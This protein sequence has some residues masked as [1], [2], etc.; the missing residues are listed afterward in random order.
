[1]SSQVRAGAAAN[2]DRLVNVGALREAYYGRQPEPSDPAQ[3]V[4][5]G[6]N[7]HCGS[8]RQGTFNEG[9]V[10]AITQAICNYRRA[11]SIT[12][13]L[14]LGRDTHA[15]SE[16]A[17]MTA[18]EVLVANRVECVIDAAD[19]PTP[20]PAVSHAVVTCNRHRASG[21]ADGIVIT[22]SHDPPED[23]GLKYSP[24]HGGPAGPDDSRWIEDQANAL[25]A[26]SLTSVARIPYRR[27]RSVAT[28]RRYDYV[29]SYV[30]E[31]STVLDLDLIRLSKLRIGV[32]PMGGSS[33]AIWRLIFERCELDVE[34]INA[35]VDP[36][37]SFVPADRDGRIRMD[38][39]S[40]H[41]MAAL[42]ERK[43][44]FDIAIG[45]DP[46]A[47]R[48]GIVTRRGGL[49]N[50]NQYL[51]LA[52]LYLFK[53]RPGWRAGAAVGKTV[54]SSSV[55]DRAAVRTG[56]VVVEVP[57]GFTWLAPGLLDGSLG[58]AAD[59]SAG[60]S[61]LR[62]DGTVWTTDQDGIVLGL[63]AAE[64]MARMGRDPADLYA[65]LTGESG[66]SVYERIDVPATEEEKARLLMLSP[67]DIRVWD[68]AG[69]PIDARLTK[70][71][72]NGAL[73]GGVK[74]ITPHGWFVARPSAAHPAY[75][76]YAESFRGP[77]HLR[78]IQEEAQTIVGHA[79]RRRS[80]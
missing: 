60:A 62:R 71:P 3:R 54:A 68:L 69:D 10:L 24:P 11:H 25:L 27:A 4:R 52:V 39:S 14:Y 36:T 41:A 18:L 45:N 76:L 29:D 64:I 15:L 37:F 63:L 2:D 48:H 70:A 32:D 47:V 49:M 42:V 55:I 31:L 1:M 40:R 67:G 53:H 34:L 80:R 51:A 57:V 6:R 8:S 65:D 19:G 78:R 5:M 44:R 79:L 75:E 30:S 23:G 56:R 72:G 9:H 61:F 46:D 74:V 58:F 12:G 33:V 66:V 16:P 73:I 17:F 77:D 35:A 22:A 7:G 50:P 13:P 20:T 43:A 28:L 38:C 21:L 59:E 26:R